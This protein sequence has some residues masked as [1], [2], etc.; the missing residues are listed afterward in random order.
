M[1]LGRPIR[2][3]RRGLGALSVHRAGSSEVARCP[4][5][6]RKRWRSLPYSS[7][8]SPIGRFL[9]DDL[10]AGYRAGRFRPLDVVESAW[11]RAERAEAL[12]LWITRLTPAQVQT[13]LDRLSGRSIEELPL[14]GIPF[15][16]KDNI[17]LAGVATTAACRAFAYVPERSAT[18]VERLIGAGAIPLGK[19]NLDQFATGLVGTRSP[20]GI[21]RNSF[22]RD[23]VSG[24]SSSGSAIAAALGIANFALGTDTAGSGRVPAAFNNIVGL[25]P[26]LGRLSSEGSVP[27][28][29]SLDC[30]SVFSLSCTDADAVLKVLA[31][32]R[33]TPAIG[34]H[35]RF[36]VLGAR[37]AEFF[38]DE[39]YAALYAQAIGRLKAMGGTPVEIDYAPFLGAAQ[40]LYSGP[41][42]AERT[43]AVGAFIEGAREADIWPATREIILRGRKYSAVDAF[44]GQYKLAA[45]RARAEAESKDLAFLMLPTAGTIYRVADIER[46]PMR[47]NINLG[48]YTNFVNFFGLSALAL[49]AG[50]RPDGL[51]FGITLIAQPQA[52]HALL[53]FGARWQRALPLPLGK[54]ASRL[55]PIDADPVAI[56]DRMSIAVVGSHMSGLPLNGQ[57]VELGGRLESAS[58]TTP[59]YRFYALPGGPPHRPGLVRVG[60]E[61]GAIELEV[62]SLPAAAVGAFLR[63]IP[64][65]L[66][67]GTVS[68]ADGSDVT[69]FLCES[70]ATAGA[71]DITA[72]GGWRAYLK[73]LAV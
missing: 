41:W 20:Y 40:L 45:F 9:L 14:Y 30:I 7:C 49:P 73:T 31:E 35:F 72:L 53:A 5:I 67:L 44:E 23:Y 1:P 38:G 10:R 58:K 18:V 19:T 42:V 6:G 2:A 22:N 48:H 37:D 71:R 39:A 62:W 63:K 57:L 33:A 21:C 11:E 32:P 64:A 54:T 36:G 8:M 69:G 12:N 55:P 61:G 52:E 70:H 43:A 60:A 25:K 50:F 15:V 34:E 17:D 28:C 13:Y 56:E 3:P 46:E 47:Y 65:P 29:R 66:G 27:A 24:G 16:I 4:D 26:S 59:H 68:L 51:P